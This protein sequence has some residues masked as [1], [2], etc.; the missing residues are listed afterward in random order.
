[1]PAA[2]PSS[3][4]VRAVLSV[5]GFRRLLGV[6]LLSQLTDGLF[7]AGLAG[8]V[9]FNPQSEN[10][11]LAIATG[12]A[13]LLLPYSLIGPYV[14]VVLDRWS[15]RTI[16]FVTNL[17][18]AALVVPTAALIYTG[19]HNLGFIVLALVIIGL[20]R[21]FLA[22]L[23]AATPHV[24]ED[25]RLVTA[26]ALA[27]TLG[28][29]SFSVGLGLAVL[30]TQVLTVGDHAYGVLA[31][32]API[33]YAA[34]ALLVRRSYRRDGLGP[35]HTGEPAGSVLAA[36]TDVARGMVAGL[37]HLASRRGAAVAMVAQAVHRGLYGVLTLAGLLLYRYY[38]YADG[39]ADELS[40][41]LSGLGLVFVAGSA[42]VLVGAFVTPPV[43]RRIG[44]WR[45]VTALLAGVGVVVAAFGLPF[46]PELLAVAVF[47]LNVAAQGIKIVVDTAL[48]HECDDDF[49]GRV[50]SVNDTT[51]NLAFV[52]GL[53]AA[54]TTLPGNGYSPTTVVVIA[55]G[56]LVVAAWYGV[57]A[58]RW[59]RQ[60]GDDIAEPEALARTGDRT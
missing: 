44:G 42:G 7:Q 53:F 37:R 16:L 41:A 48:Q 9:L 55:V 33:G 21:L 20:N 14:G 51:F 11:P 36:A 27:G 17:V 49:R 24:V 28:S 54:A 50:F 35:D 18:R 32:V 43:T 30:S 6:R 34:S 56:Y 23:S 3:H 25:R 10:S 31:A 58:G 4:N 13:I 15:R 22:G 39:D 29:I 47:F 12:F 59:A 26:N 46:E 60:E 52:T 19:A 2:G 5:G 40:S 57:F 1:M 38:F 45:W 8:S